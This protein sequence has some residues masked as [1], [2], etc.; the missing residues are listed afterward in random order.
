[1]LHC[2]VRHGD[3]DGA[4][5]VTRML[6]TDVIGVREV[7]AAEVAYVQAL[8]RHVV[9]LVAIA[10]WSSIRPA[11]ELLHKAPASESERIGTASFEGHLR[12]VVGDGKG[13]GRFL[14][15]LANE[16]GQVGARIHL[17]VCELFGIGRG[18]YQKLDAVVHVR[19]GGNCIR[20]SQV[21]DSSLVA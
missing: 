8:Q 1:M 11:H 14:E 18:S 19:D 15:L 6:W 17:P 16:V 4:E 13:P 2:A 21:I 5:D 20:E 3:G 10:V 12:D 9:E 7:G